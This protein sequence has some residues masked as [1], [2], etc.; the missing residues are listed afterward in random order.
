[1]HKASKFLLL[2]I[3]AACHAAVGAVSAQPSVT[4]QDDSGYKAQDGV[5]VLTVDGTKDLGPI[6][7]MNAVNNGPN[8]SLDANK[9]QEQRSGHFVHYR[10]MRTPMAR[11]HDS[12]NM[13][14]PPGHMGDINLIFP[15]WSADRRAS[16]RRTGRSASSPIARPTRCRSTSSRGTPTRGRPRNASRARHQKVCEQSYFRP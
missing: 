7:P 12:R 3:V 1:M 13:G 8:F 2:P 14:S 9:R 15:D 11:L 10:N 6:K 4:V 16:P 5:L